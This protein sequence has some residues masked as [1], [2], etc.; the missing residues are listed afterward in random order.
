MAV[1]VHRGA[2]F[3]VFLA[4]Q[5]DDDLVAGPQHIIVL[6]RAGLGHHHGGRASQPIVTELLQ[7][8]A[9][10]RRHDLL[11]SRRL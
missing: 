6:H 1:T 10:A 3:A 11:K 5:H 9:G 2:I 8:D 4:P 7:G